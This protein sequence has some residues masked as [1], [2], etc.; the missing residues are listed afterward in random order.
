[1]LIRKQTRTGEKYGSSTL[2]EWG[3]GINWLTKSI[4]NKEQKAI[5]SFTNL[6]QTDSF[7]KCRQ[8]SMEKK[9]QS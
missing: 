3:P 2:Q 4:G 5:F 1:M 7:V 8:A 9:S 6:Q